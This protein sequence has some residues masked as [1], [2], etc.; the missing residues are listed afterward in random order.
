MQII[1]IRLIMSRVSRIEARTALLAVIL[2][3]PVVV[4]DS[5]Q[6]YNEIYLAI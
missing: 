5:C 2:A 4:V 3:Q 6:K 1:E